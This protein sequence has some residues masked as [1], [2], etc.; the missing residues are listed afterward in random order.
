MND[1]IEFFL[2]V[3]G[4]DKKY[5]PVIY[6]CHDYKKDIK[7]LSIR[8]G[9]TSDFYWERPFPLKNF[10]VNKIKPFI[11]NDRKTSYEIKLC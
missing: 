1:K 2:Y 6:Q 7:Y 10:K 9:I 4:Y 5:D 8:T 3:Y 11:K